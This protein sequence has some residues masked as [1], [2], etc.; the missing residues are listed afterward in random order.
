MDESGKRAKTIKQETR[1]AF[2]LVAGWP[3][4]TVDVNLTGQF[5]E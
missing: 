2:L 5:G 4:G 1:G 3:D